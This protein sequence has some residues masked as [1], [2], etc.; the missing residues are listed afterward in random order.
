MCN[1]PASLPVTVVWSA[2]NCHH[3]LL[4][5]PQEALTDQLVCPDDEPKPIHVVE[6]LADILQAS[7]QNAGQVTLRTHLELSQSIGQ[8]PGI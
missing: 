6:M 5:L 8:Q 1:A 7:Q 3:L 2:E 4:V